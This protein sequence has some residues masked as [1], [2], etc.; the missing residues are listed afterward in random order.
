L[1]IRLLARKSPSGIVGRRVVPG[2]D[3]AMTGIDRLVIAGCY[4][5]AFLDFLLINDDL[6]LL[7]RRP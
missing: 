6:H 2:F 4:L 5:P 7:A 1:A 3:I